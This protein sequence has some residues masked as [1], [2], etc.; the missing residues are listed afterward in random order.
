VPHEQ[1]AAGSRTSSPA[2]RARRVPMR[3]NSLGAGRR[4]PP[5]T[6]EFGDWDIG[7][8]GR[9][10]CWHTAAETGALLEITTR[11]L[12]QLENL[13]MPARGSRGS[14]R[15]P[16]PHAC[17]WFAMYHVEFELARLGLG[18]RP[19]HLDVE[20]AFERH[21]KMNAVEDV[22]FEYPNAPQPRAARQLREALAR[23]QGLRP[24]GGSGQ[25]GS[26]GQIDAACGTNPTRT[27]LAGVLACIRSG[28]ATNGDIATLT[29]CTRPHAELRDP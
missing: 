3:A 15:Y 21:D 4:T 29:P 25:S 18:H 11:S 13:G 9:L 8:D 24:L 1:L 6:D 27:V 7:P 14:C 26:D 20:D 10:T 5:F 12:L 28:V 22:E 19:A 17:V 16:W 2:G 23:G